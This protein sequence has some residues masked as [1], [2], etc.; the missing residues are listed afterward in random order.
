[1]RQVGYLAAAAIYALDH[2][3][4]RLKIDHERARSIGSELTK[5]SW[6]NDVMPI[7]TNILIFSVDDVTAVMQKL[8]EAGVMAVPFGP[9]QIRFVTH[10]DF[11]DDDLERT[12]SALQSV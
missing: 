2:N 7:D 4:D 8:K 5:L 3:I 6:V 1:M 11:T 10:L 12:V 9:N